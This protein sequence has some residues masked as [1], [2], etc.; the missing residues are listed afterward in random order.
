MLKCTHLQFF[1]NYFHNISEYDNMMIKQRQVFYPKF[2]LYFIYF[3]QIEQNLVKR[4]YT[5]V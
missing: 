5:K 4:K 1:Y 2:I 3:C